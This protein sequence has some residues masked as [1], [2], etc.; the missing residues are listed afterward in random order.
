MNEKMLQIVIRRNNELGFIAGVQ[1]CCWIQFRW[2]YFI[3]ILI[4]W[5]QKTPVRAVTSA[6]S[7]SWFCTSCEIVYS[8][9]YQI[10]TT[11]SLEEEFCPENYKNIRELGRMGGR[12]I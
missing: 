12:K 11:V 7:L 5:Q 6:Y 9:K 1:L 2:W 8:F 10:N 3:E 4:C